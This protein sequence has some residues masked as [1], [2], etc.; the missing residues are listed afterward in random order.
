MII[1]HEQ[2]ALFDL[3]I[4]AGFSEVKAELWS[5]FVEATV[6]ILDEAGDILRQP[7]A[8]LAYIAK[9]GAISTP[10]RKGKT[11]VERVPIEDGITAE[12]GHIARRLRRAVGLDDF[13]RQQEVVF[14]TE[15]LVESSNRTGRYSRKVDFFVYSQLGSNAPQ[16]ALEAKPLRSVADIGGRYLAEEGIGCF[17]TT[18]SVYTTQPIAGMIAYT[19][20]EGSVSHLDDIMSE[21]EGL[22]RQVPVKRFAIPPKPIVLLLS[23]H[24]RIAL[25]LPSIAIVHFEML[26]PLEQTDLAP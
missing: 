9:R 12:L 11:K 24:D 26:F 25:S 15:Y 17:F 14:E 22:D 4:D 8:W 21:I 18:D 16:F 19:T 5:R 6:Q 3:L 13:L 7:D 2:P 1:A 20:N 10:K 23:G